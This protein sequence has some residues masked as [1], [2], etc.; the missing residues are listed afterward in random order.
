[1]WIFVQTVGI[2]PPP[3]R[4]SCEWDQGYRNG[5]TDETVM[6]LVSVNAS[7]TEI[8]RVVFGSGAVT[9][10]IFCHWSV[11]RLACSQCLQLTVKSTLNV[12]IVYV[13]IS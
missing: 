6:L 8:C 3:P 11:L 4:P 12:E 2:V 5:D 1:M 7:L 13:E 9:R 10:Q